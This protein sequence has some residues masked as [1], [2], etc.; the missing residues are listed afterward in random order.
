M[1]LHPVCL[2]LGISKQW[3]CEGQAALTRRTSA[4]VGGWVVHGNV[5]W[6]ETS[7]RMEFVSQGCIQWDMLLLRI[8]MAECVRKLHLTDI[9]KQESVRS[10]DVPNLEQG[11]G[12]P[13]QVPGLAVRGSHTSCNGGWGRQE[14]RSV[15]QVGERLRL[16]LAG[17]FLEWGEGS[18][19]CW[20]FS[21]DGNA[22][23]QQEQKGS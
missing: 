14:K 7:N 4:F 17:L 13:A 6:K 22:T 12:D 20:E 10:N 11:D 1:N 8:F 15:R 18:R 19:N 23:T 5:I 9:F 3:S 2:E 21:L 16:C